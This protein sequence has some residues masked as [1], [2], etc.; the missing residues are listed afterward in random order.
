MKKITKYGLAL[1][2][3]AAAGG[4]LWF[5]WN[6][7]KTAPEPQTFVPVSESE[8][9]DIPDTPPDT[10][11]F[12]DDR[13]AAAYK[14][15]KIGGKTWMAENLR[16]RAKGSWC[17]GDDSSYCDKYGRLYVW[18]TAKTACPT[19]WHLPTRQEWVALSEAAGGEEAAGKRLKAKAGWDEDGGGTDKHGFSALPGGSRHHSA[20]DFSYAGGTGFWWTSTEYDGGG[21]DNAYI[22]AMNYGDNDVGESY[23][24]KGG[25][26]SVRC[27]QND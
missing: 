14:T 18:N 8:S 7:K 5:W 2:L 11:S 9:E 17:Y 23:G 4:A 1:L 12:T 16:Y 24:G 19:G 22:R 26:L 10:G 15:A 20:G 25:G 21:N 6:T 27:V 3:T 13:D